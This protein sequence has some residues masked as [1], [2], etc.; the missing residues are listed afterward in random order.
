MTMPAWWGERRFGLFVHATPASVPGWAP[1]GELAEWYRS[2]LGENV[3]DDVLHRQPLAEVLA[4]HRDRWGHV[5]GY[6]D[7]VP[8]LTF[9]AFDADDWAKLVSDAGANYTILVT[10]HHDG[11]TW[12]DAPGSTRPLTEDGPH[13]DV[14]AEYAAACERHGLTLGTYYSLLDWGDR[15]YPDENYVDQVLHPQ[16]IDLVERHR[17]KMLWGDGHWTHDAGHW[18]TAQL[19]ERV[20][21][22]DP[23]LVINDRWRASSSDVPEGAPPIVRT[24]EYDPPTGVVEGPW[25]LTRGIGLSFGY[26]RAE[27]SE[28]HLS[29]LEIVALYTEVLAKGGNLLLNVGPDSTGRIPS[30]QSEPL[31]QAGT[32]IRRYG[33]VLAGTT[34]WKT[35]GDSDSRYL[36]EPG[37]STDSVFAIDIA[38]TGCFSALTANE[39]RVT[40][41]E[42]VDRRAVDVVWHQDDDGL[43]VSTPRLEAH[44]AT[45]EDDPVDV[46]VYRAIVEA[47]ER[48]DALFAPI[49]PTPTQLAPL[50]AD[51]RAGDIV[52]LGDG[53]YTGPAEIPPGVVLRGLGAARTT[54]AQ[55]DDTAPSIVPTAPTLTVG[56]HARVEHAR[57]T[58]SA[59]AHDVVARA[60]VSITG[61]A[62]TM[63]GCSVDGAV[64]V[65]ADDALVKAV[66]ARG[67]IGHNADR[68]H[69]SRCNFTGRRWDVGI[70][71]RGGGGHQVESNR[72]SGHLCAIR[73]S[74]TTGSTVRGNTVSGRWWGVHIA[75]CEGAH[76]H[77]NRI[78]WTMRA[79]DVDGGTQAVVDGNAVTDGDSGCVVTDG[80]SDCEVYGNFWE[81]CRI[82]LLAWDAVS[83]HHQD[84]VTSSLHEPDATFITGP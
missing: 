59:A 40:D 25:E 24:F 70:D 58:G 41:V 63:L 69:V 66:S 5:Q 71:L 65:T 38:G 48:P 23:E 31:R 47:V 74:E 56:R 39:V 33:P 84:N 72:L 79:V 19:L 67:V 36:R 49:E 43:H 28:H 4:H 55:V 61:E 20:R 18:K 3:D 15:R 76:V 8:L 51:A 13:R 14:L 22:I 16:V 9:E 21:G 81:R 42:L 53:V 45:A 73:A 2:H 32:W 62:A 52:Q 60:V 50:L 17:S 82:G 30:T 64:E 35:W 1:I 34:P 29:G 12:W 57:V 11:W 75:R 78:S 27:R 77:G 10:K 26:N 83:L 37:G 44:P 80:A 6:D 54:I 68:L 7:F 46:G